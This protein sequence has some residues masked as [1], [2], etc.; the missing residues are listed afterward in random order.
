MVTLTRN[1]AQEQAI[2]EQRYSFA[3]SV[4][5][6]TIIKSSPKAAAIAEQIG[7]LYAEK[8]RH[9]AI[10]TEYKYKV[11][12]RN[13]SPKYL[14]YAAQSTAKVRQIDAQIEALNTQIFEIH[15]EFRAKAR[16]F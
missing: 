6:D 4:D 15:L 9:E 5:R 13:Y 12:A 7:E 11:K 16:R 14:E 10:A 2:A 3:I 1:T 8:S